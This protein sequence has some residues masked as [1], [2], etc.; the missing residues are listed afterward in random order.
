[1]GS[2]VEFTREVQ[3][4]NVLDLTNPSVRTQ[5]GIDYHDIA[6]NSYEKTK[7]IGTWARANGYDGILAPSARSN[8]SN[9]VYW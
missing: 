1:M 4:N 3:L 8:G 7:Q 2:R 9:L 6:G 5:L